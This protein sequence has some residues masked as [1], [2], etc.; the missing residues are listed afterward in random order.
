V[1]EDRRK[2]ESEI[3]IACGQACRRKNEKLI[4]LWIIVKK[5]IMSRLF[6]S[7]AIFFILNL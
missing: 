7:V 1:V 6:S 2:I 4:F 5:E 3:S